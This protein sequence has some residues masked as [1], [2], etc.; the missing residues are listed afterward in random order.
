MTSLYEFVELC[1]PAA[2]L[3]DAKLLCAATGAEGMTE[4]ALGVPAWP[5]GTE[6]V[7]ADTG[8]PDLALSPPATHYY[9]VGFAHIDALQ[10]LPESLVVADAV[11]GVSQRAIRAVAANKAKAVK[12]PP[13]KVNPGKGDELRNAIATDKR[14][15]KQRVD[16]VLLAMDLRR[17]KNVGSLLIQRGLILR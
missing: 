14:P 2:D 12:D 17:S 7:Y 5:D 9:N 15:T 10:K 8:W 3:A 4:A 6:L 11:Q 1:V 16:A 13:P